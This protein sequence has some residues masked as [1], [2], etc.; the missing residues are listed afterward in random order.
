MATIPSV[1]SILMSLYQCRF[2]RTTKPPR[3]KDSPVSVVLLTWPCEAWN[4]VAERPPLA[5]AR[6]Q[7]TAICA[8]SA[9]TSSGWVSKSKDCVIRREFTPSGSNGFGCVSISKPSFNLREHEGAPCKSAWKYRS[10]DERC[11]LTM[12]SFPFASR[13]PINNCP[14][15]NRVQRFPSNQNFLLRLARVTL[16]AASSLPRC[17]STFFCLCCVFSSAAF[18]PSA[19]CLSFLPL[20]K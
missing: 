19:R 20:A 12:R 2:P 11:F 1:I 15:D 9:N 5:Q 4:A 14:L 3:P 17:F 13:P 8:A 7:H 6:D 10:V 16:P 18:A